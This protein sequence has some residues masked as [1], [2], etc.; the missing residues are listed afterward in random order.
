MLRPKNYIFIILM[1]AWAF[2]N[3]TAWAAQKKNKNIIIIVVDSLRPDHL[4]C[5]GYYRNTS[6]NID[7]LSREGMKFNQAITAGGWTIESVP[8]ILTGTYF[9]MHQI[10]DKYGSETSFI[11]SLAEELAL[12]NYQTTL[13]SNYIHMKLPVIR[14]GFQEVY[15]D[16]LF[17]NNRPITTDYML[18]D[19]V[20]VWLEKQKN[21]NSPFFLYIHYWGCHIPYGLPDSYKYMYLNDKYMKEPKTIPI[22]TINKGYSKDI[23]YK[24][25]PPEVA[26]K[27]ITDINYY[28]AQY[29]GT[30]SYIDDQIYRLID[31]L[32][33]LKLY[34]DT[35]IIFTADHGEIL[36]EHDFY[37]THGIWQEETIKVPLIISS[38]DLFPKGK[39]ITK[40]VS[41]IDI[42]PTIL[43]LTG[44]K[45]PSY[46]E[47]ESLFAFVKPFRNYHAKYVL[48]T[49]KINGYLTVRTEQ[50]KLIYCKRCNYYGLFD[51]RKDPKEQNDL[52][53]QMPDKIKQLKRVLDK[54]NDKETSFDQVLLEENKDTLKNLGY[55]Q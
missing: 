8:S 6:P 12:K 51:I 18:T 33:E 48:S 19:K 45:R 29:D 32:K 39:L 42:A 16:E 46:L 24:Q 10:E 2:S 28:L 43:E 38:P 30:I 53:K 49:N 55:L 31:K 27:G 23:G 41:L 25:I 40:Q 35:V 20:K 21:N 11:K 54:Y 15:V 22:S 34:N 4:G 36:G 3:K 17:E 52:S 9:F 14:K 37:F 5:Y 50:W 44:L 26:E 7:K 47:G 13:F 1:L